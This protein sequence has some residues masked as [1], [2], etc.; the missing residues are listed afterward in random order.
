MEIKITDNIKAKYPTL[1]GLTYLVVHYTLI[2]YKERALI[3]KTESAT[4]RHTI[5]R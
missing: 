3:L 4:G 1:E 5:R 2:K